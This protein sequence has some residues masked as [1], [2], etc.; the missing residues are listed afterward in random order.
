MAAGFVNAVKRAHPSSSGEGIDVSQAYLERWG[1]CGVKLR[2]YQL[3]GVR[4]LAERDSRG[5]G[6]ILGDEMGLGKTLQV[7]SNVGGY[8]FIN[9]GILSHSSLYRCLC[10]CISI[11]RIPAHS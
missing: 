8:E 5:H 11:A 6:C 9:R 7:R 3:D 10:T 1:L 4:W 2:P